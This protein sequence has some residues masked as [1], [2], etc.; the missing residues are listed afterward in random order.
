MFPGI[1]EQNSC[2]DK[3]FCEE[4]LH[5]VVTGQELPKADFRKNPF[6]RG[7]SS[8][9]KKIW[10]GISRVTAGETTTYGALAA[11]TGST[12]AARAVGRA[13]NRNPLALIIPCHRIV[14]AKGPGGFAGD[15]SIKLKL[16]ELEN[17]EKPDKFHDRTV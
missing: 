8:F 11:A 3:L 12:G 16:L 6:L 13:C 4:L 1:N 14:A 7:G 2:N 10:K 15:I 5:K 17:Q 9:Q